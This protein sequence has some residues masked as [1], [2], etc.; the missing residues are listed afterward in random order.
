MD[1][2]MAAEINKS[3]MMKFKWVETITNEQVIDKR[4][5]CERILGRWAS[6]CVFKEVDVY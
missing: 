1:T 4:E 2:S 3:E 5:L 6:L